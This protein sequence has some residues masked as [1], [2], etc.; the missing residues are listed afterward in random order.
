MLTSADNAIYTQFT[1]CPL[2][3]LEGVPTYAHLNEF[4]AYLN[5]FT[6][7]IF[8]SG[9]CGTL[10]YLVL[11]APTANFNLLCPTVFNAPVNPG[12]SFAI[13]VP[14]QTATVLLE[15]V[16]NH[17]KELCILKEYHDVDK[18]VQ[19]KIQDYIHE[20]YYRTLKNKTTDFAKVKSLTIL[21]HLWTT[22]LIA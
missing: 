13:P 19:Q 17:Q 5:L 10:S 21:T 14:A 22:L 1:Q 7:D 15:L 12:P 2:P 3:P 4:N 18:A 8:S 6:S 20:K 16:R 11:T 9:G